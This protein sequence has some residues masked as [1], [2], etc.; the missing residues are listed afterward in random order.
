M[1]CFNHG[2]KSDH[3]FLDS[4]RRTKRNDENGTLIYEGA[5]FNMR[6]VGIGIIS[7]LVRT[8]LDKTK[9]C[10]EEAQLLPDDQKGTH[11]FIRVFL[12]LM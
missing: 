7:A 5:W 2:F 9:K 10:L 12:A 11:T 1:Y 6:N 4:C 8:G 3:K